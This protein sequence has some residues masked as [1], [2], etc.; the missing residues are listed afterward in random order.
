MATYLFYVVSHKDCKCDRGKQARSHA[1][2]ILSFLLLLLIQA[3]Q[4]PG[5]V[6]WYYPRHSVRRRVSILSSPQTGKRCLLLS[7]QKP[8][9]RWHY[10]MRLHS[11][12][13]I[14]YYAAL[15]FSLILVAV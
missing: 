5:N 15:C 10:S 4:R 14:P 13:A 11:T 9:K 1:K 8:L 12:G 2:G 3:F 6:F 7:L